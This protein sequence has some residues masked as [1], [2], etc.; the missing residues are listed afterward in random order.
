MSD[1]DSLLAQ[2]EEV[3]AA[4]G[5]AY[6][7]YSCG[8][9]TRCCR[10]AV[11]GRE[12]YLTSLELAYLLRGI[13]QRGGMLSQKRR[14]LP[15]LPAVAHDQEGTCPLLNQDSMCSSYAHRP[16]GCRSF[17]CND[18]DDGG[19]AVRHK[20]LQRFVR[21]IKDLSLIHIS[22]PTRPY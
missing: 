12:P 11:T 16:L 9:S 1:E 8:Q 6:G 7:G 21:K 14:A 18:A 22:E 4:V 13:R 19:R 17:W 20:E 3:Y 15:L 5:D 2:L 10:F